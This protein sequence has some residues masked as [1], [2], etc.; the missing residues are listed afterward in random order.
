[1]DLAV[2]IAKTFRD[3]ATYES[4][5]SSAKGRGLVNGVLA[6]ATERIPVRAGRYLGGSAKRPAT[7]PPAPPAVGAFLKEVPGGQ[8]YRRRNA[9]RAAGGWRRPAAADPWSAES[10]WRWNCLA[11]SVRQRAHL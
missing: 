10:H 2:L 5:T 6:F 8:G 3:R 1:M 7:V 11:G 4:R 9:A